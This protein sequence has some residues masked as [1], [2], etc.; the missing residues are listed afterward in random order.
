[1]ALSPHGRSMRP[2]IRGGRD[3]VVVEPLRHAPRRGELVMYA[4]RDGLYIIHRIVGVSDGRYLTRGDNCI[5]CE[6]V[7][8]ERMVGVVVEICRGG[9]HISVDDWQYRA[10]VWLWM[11]LAPLRMAVY[12]LI[13]RARRA[14]RNCSDVPRTP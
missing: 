1:M 9:R 5:S 14:G 7:P 2:L 12:G 4:K 8:R 11:R 13:A 3:T 10:Y 6:C